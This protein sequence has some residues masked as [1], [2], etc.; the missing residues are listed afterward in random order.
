MAT[1]FENRRTERLIMRLQISELKKGDKFAEYDSGCVAFCE[2][3][4]DPRRVELP[5]KDGWEIN[6][7]IE[8]KG[9]GGY[10]DTEFFESVNAGAYGLKLYAQS[11]FR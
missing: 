3:L 1:L 5:G 10:Y 9:K 4:E 11:E 8:N 7:R 6:V 2:A